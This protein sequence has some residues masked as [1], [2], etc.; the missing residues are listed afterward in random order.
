MRNKITVIGAGNVGATTA[1][2]VAQKELGD[3]VLV[4]IAE[5]IPQGKGLDMN[6]TGPVEMYDSLVTGTNGYEETA[7]SQ[8]VIVTA[9]IARKPGMSREDLLKTNAAIVGGC[10]EEAHKRSPEAIFIIVSNPLDVMTYLAY[11]KTN[12]PSE[13]VMGMAGVLDT[14]RYKFFISEALGVSQKDISA[15]VLGGHG[16]TMVA[17]PRYT[18]ISGIPLTELLPADK[19]DAICERTAKGGAEIVG[20]LKTGSAYYAPAASSAQMAESILRDQKRVLPVCAWL[21]GQY[22]LKDMY[23]GVPAVI[24]SNGVER[25]IELQLNDEEKAKLANSAAATKKATEELGI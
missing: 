19:I 11:R 8:V 24:G 12:L 17:L 9:G 2:Y 6:Q 1:L 21:T 13:K 25:I 5:G 7:G 15:L 4:D 22:G 23:M 18:T 16:D 3:V 14:A 20:L 10:V